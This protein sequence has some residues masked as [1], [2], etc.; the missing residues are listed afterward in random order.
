MAEVTLTRPAPEGIPDAWPA[1]PYYAGATLWSWM[2]ST[3]HKKIGIMYLVSVCFFLGVGGALAM[4]I[5]LEHLTPGPTIMGSAETYDRIF[6][7]HGVIMVWA[8][9]IPSIPAAFGNF[10]LPIMVGA[11]DVA[12]P[13]LNL[14]S[15]WVYLLGGLM[16]LGSAAWN[17]ADT[18]WTFYPP[19]SAETLTAVT[20]VA[21][22]VFILGVSTIITGI[23]FIVTTHTLRGKGLT[24]SK[25]PVFVWTLYATSIIQV[26]ATPVLGITLLLIGMD[27][28][29]SLGLFDPAVGGDPVLYQHMFWFYSHP[30]VYIMILPAMGVMAEV[31]SA[32][33]QK[34]YYTYRGLVISGLGIAFV[35]F[36]TWGHHMFVAG[37][38]TL[39][40]GFFGLSSMLVAIFSAIKVFSWTGTM[41]KGSIS[42]KTPML[43]FLQFLFLFSVGGTTGVALASTSLDVHWHDTYFVVAHFHFIMV[44]GT[45]TGF[46]ASLHYWWPKITGKMY[47][48]TL[49]VIA[50]ILVF[51]GFLGTFVP[52]F[53][54]GNEGMPRRYFNYPARFQSLHVISTVGSWSFAAGLSLVLF[55]LLNSLWRGKRSEPNPWHSKGLEWMGPTP[56]PEHNFEVPPTYYGREPHDYWR[57][58]ELG[59]VR[60]EGGAHG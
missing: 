39:D 50:S 35:S 15:F 42:L 10:L 22:A 46:L 18:G 45:L 59:G 13:R 31:V 12:F 36:V 49:A 28:W 41:Y 9:M 6:T 20:P 4:M 40:V 47:D 2:T 33:S 24:W 7:M 37:M 52:Q 26:L 54:L 55:Y 19:Y 51:M 1:K 16:L 57:P 27:H 8:F 60:E 34:N 30:A 25:L 14:T 38:S 56:P 29:F 23:N 53:L 43:Y 3:D 58:E 32:F 11:K 21:I 5:R 17:A 48:E 44:G